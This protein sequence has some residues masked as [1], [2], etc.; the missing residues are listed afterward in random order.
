MVVA[1]SQHVW[2][3]FINRVRMQPATL[4]M[5]KPRFSRLCNWRPIRTQIST[6]ICRKPKHGMRRD[7][8]RPDCAVSLVGAQTSQTT[9]RPWWATPRSRHNRIP[10]APGLQSSWLLLLLCGA[11]RLN[12]MRVC[13][14]TPRLL[15]LRS[16][17]QRWCGAWPSCRPSMGPSTRLVCG[18]MGALAAGHGHAGPPFGG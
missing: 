1:A 12:C 5:C 4:A 11:T 17:M 18:A 10:G 2:S 9:P 13:C 15:L 16:T 6:C 3:W 14:L 7:K 8:S